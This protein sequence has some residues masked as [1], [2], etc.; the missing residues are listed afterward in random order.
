MK[1]SYYIQVKKQALPIIEHYKDDLL[2]H[3]RKALTGYAGRFVHSTRKTGTFLSKL[4]NRE[5]VIK[6]IIQ[7]NGK[8]GAIKQGYNK[9]LDD[10][11]LMHTFYHEDMNKMYLI[12]EAG[13]IRKV[14]REKAYQFAMDVLKQYIPVINETKV[15]TF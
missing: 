14:T 10:V 5:E 2:K 1:D 15:N 9:W 8:E 13:K 3:D 11:F 12:G 7:R 6:D 4:D